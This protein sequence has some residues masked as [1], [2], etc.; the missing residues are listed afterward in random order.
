MVEATRSGHLGGAGRFATPQAAALERTVRD[1]LAAAGVA[2]ADVDYVECAAAGALLADAAEIEALGEVFDD[3]SRPVPVGTVKP[4]IGHLEAAAGLSQLVKVLL[5][6]RH[7]Q[8]A[9]TLFGGTAGA[10]WPKGL[11]RSDHLAFWPGGEPARA[12]VNAVGATGSYGH[13]LLRSAVSPHGGTAGDTGERYAFPLSAQ[14]DAGLAALARRLH[15]HLETDRPAP[16]DVAFTLQ[17]GRR[18]LE[19]RA[20]VEAATLGELCAA[21]AALGRGEPVPA[22]GDPLLRDWLSGRAAALAAPR[23][24]RRIPLP[25]EPFRPARH[26]LDAAPDVTA[27]VPGPVTATAS[28]PGGPGPAT[29]EHLIAVYAQVSG[30]PVDRLDPDAP[31]EDYGLSSAQIVQIT[32]RLT[33]DLGRDVPSTL[34][35]AHRTLAGVAGELDAPSPASRTATGTAAPATVSRTADGAA[36]PAGDGRIAVVGIAGRYPQ[37]GN[38]EEL[39]QHLLAGRDLVT[40]LPEGRRGTQPVGAEPPTGGFLDEVAGFDPLFFG[41]TPRD[42]A[43]M[44]PQERLFLQTAWHTLEDAGWTRAVLRERHGGRVGVFVGSMYNEYPFYGLNGPRPVGSAIAGIANRVSYFLDLSGPSMTVDTMCSSSLTA[45]H[46]AVS[47][48]RGGECEAA[49]VGGV[50]LSLHPNKFAALDEL[51]MASTDHRCRSFGDGRRR[52][53]TGGGRGR[54]TAQAAGQGPRGRRPDPRGGA[55]HRRQPRRPDQRL[56]R[57][58]SAGTGGSR[59]PGTAGRRCRPG[60]DRLRGGARHRYVARR[61]RRGRRPAPGVRRRP[62]GRRTAVAHRI[63]QVEH[64]PPGGRGRH[65]RTDQDGPP[66]PARHPRAVPARTGTQPRDRLGERPVPCAARGRALAGRHTPPGG[67][68]LLRGGRHQRA[69]RSSRPR[70]SARPPSRLPNRPPSPS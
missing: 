48:L 24:A 6:F 29:L 65:R 8:T 45:V 14:T 1:T 39:W 2:P 34:F 59:R 60:R 31:L 32:A 30:V 67:H 18:H 58:Q 63:G 21:L 20:V 11:C 69:H 55:R 22:V 42:A 35:F 52:V 53:R 62:A 17:S 27:S 28:V 19:R 66:V 33:E 4:N 46:L 44:D 56:H 41:I 40:P 3:P 16:R 36:P 26:R 61:P 5:Q 38:V 25:N 43:A 51:G 68:Q 57:A 47:A 70:R 49:L 12:L 23:R 54:G 64:R 37:A 15:R 13:A 7:G 10:E 50:N 9:P